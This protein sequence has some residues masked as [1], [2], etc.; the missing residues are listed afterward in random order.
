[1]VDGM[2]IRK[3]PF[4]LHFLLSPHTLKMMS[5]VYPETWASPIILKLF[6]FYLCVCVCVCVCVCF[7]TPLTKE[8]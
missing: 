6:L 7:K 8:Q 5:A 4:F 3:F 1:M 2:L